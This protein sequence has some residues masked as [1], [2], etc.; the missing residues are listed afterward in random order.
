MTKEA[1]LLT[2]HFSLVWRL[3]EVLFLCVMEWLLILY[4]VLSKTEATHKRDQ[5]ILNSNIQAHISNQ[6]MPNLSF[7]F[8]KNFNWWKLSKSCQ[9]ILPGISNILQC[10]SSRILL[11]PSLLFLIMIPLHLS[12]LFLMLT[13][14]IKL[15]LWT[16]PWMIQGTF[17]PLI[18]QFVFSMHE[19]EILKN[20]LF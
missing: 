11:H 2:L 13:S 20:G 1:M 12:S 16:K 18:P 19:S 14:S 10:I 5:T 17:L 9:R 8:P 15:S 7:K 3:V 4:L 6:I